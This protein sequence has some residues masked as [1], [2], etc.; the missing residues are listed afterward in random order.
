[1]EKKALDSQYR[2]GIII[3]TLD[4]LFVRASLMVVYR[5]FVSVYWVLLW[6]VWNFFLVE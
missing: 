2:L 4:S 6:S 5:P 1:M 3:Q